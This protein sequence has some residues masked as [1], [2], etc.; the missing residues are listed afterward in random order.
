[1]LIV[2]KQLLCH[3]SAIS[4]TKTQLPQS[5]NMRSTITLSIAALASLSAGQATPQNNY[6]YR[7]D[8]DSV[9]STDRGPYSIPLQPGRR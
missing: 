6:P 1:M 9:S 4:I 3:I 2:Y 7:I 5:T 8:P